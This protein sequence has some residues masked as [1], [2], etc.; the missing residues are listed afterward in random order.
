MKIYRYVFHGDKQL[1]LNY[2]WVEVHAE[3]I[4]DADKKFR[5]V[6]PD[7]IPGILNCSEV[8]AEEWWN[9]SFI[10]RGASQYK[11]FMVIDKVKVCVVVQEI[12]RR[13]IVI[14]TSSIEKAC[15]LVQKKYDNEEIVLGPEDMV[16]MPKGEYIYP[17]EWYTNEE[18]QE[19]EADYEI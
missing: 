19:M 17:A 18:V 7:K 4:D 13:E 1:P 10:G 15:E 6:F 8:Y 12:L 3:N 2:G 11:C 14:E 9:R 5:L 16:S